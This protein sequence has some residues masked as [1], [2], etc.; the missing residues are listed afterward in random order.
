M[1]QTPTVTNKA[2]TEQLSHL[3]ARIGRP[4]LEGRFVALLLITVDE[5]SL[6]DAA[7]LLSVTKNA[8]LK[9]A[10]PMLERGD[11]KRSRDP[12]TRQ[13]LYS[14]TDHAYIRDLRTQADL[15]RAVSAI[16]GQF[17]ASRRKLH[18]EAKR[19]LSNHSLVAWRATEALERVLKPEE[20]AQEADI[21]QHLEQDWDALPPRRGRGRHPKSGS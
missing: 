9:T 10:T 3:Y 11:V 18:P 16:T 4:P 2:F 8:L 19:R 17:L 20:R 13:H 12:R 7:E 6:G 5:I 15:S 14:L 1:C 21:E